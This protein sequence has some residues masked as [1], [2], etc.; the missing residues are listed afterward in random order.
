VF[1]PGDRLYADTLGEHWALE[2]VRLD[3]VAI[4]IALEDLLKHDIKFLYEKLSKQLY[5]F[6]LQLLKFVI[7]M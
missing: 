4:L 6:T 3:C 1:V 2:V 7:F 5:L